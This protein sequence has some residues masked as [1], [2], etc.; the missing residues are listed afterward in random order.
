MATWD[1]KEGNTF[2]KRIVKRL[3]SL[4]IQCDDKLHCNARDHLARTFYV[5][6][7]DNFD[8]A[9]CELTADKICDYMGPLVEIKI[10]A[11]ITPI[12]GTEIVK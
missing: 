7:G 12:K 5:F 1:S 8:L 2:E 4:K 9:I 6:G 10:T 11:E 3:C